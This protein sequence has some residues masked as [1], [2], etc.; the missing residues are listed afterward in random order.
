MLAVE[1]ERGDGTKLVVFL[2]LVIVFPGE[3]LWWGSDTY[4][5]DAVDLKDRM[6]MTL[7]FFKQSMTVSLCLSTKLCLIALKGN[8]L[9]ILAHQQIIS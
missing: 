3:L 1:V 9:K 2:V 7:H 5:A 4:A 8:R 6:I